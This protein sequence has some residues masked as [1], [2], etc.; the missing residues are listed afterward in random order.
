[1]DKWFI[2]VLNLKP[3]KIMA[4]VF[5]LPSGFE[6]PEFDWQDIEKYQKDYFWLKY[7]D[8]SKFL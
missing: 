1:M 7:C 8:F 6:A 2:F 3:K 4:K 5:L